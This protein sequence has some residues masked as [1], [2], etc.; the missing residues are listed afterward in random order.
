MTKLDNILAKRGMVPT[1]F[2]CACCNDTFDR[3]EVAPSNALAPV[4]MDAIRARFGKLVCTY[5][6]ESMLFCDDTGVALVEGEEVRDHEGNIFV[7][8]G[9]AA[10]Y[11]REM[12]ALAETIRDE[13]RAYRNAIGHF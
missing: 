13:S 9:V 12:A 5:C 2:K 11:H 8:N 10:D 7:S 3:D 4:F 1:M 6:A